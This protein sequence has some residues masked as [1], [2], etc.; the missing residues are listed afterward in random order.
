MSYNEED[1]L[2]VLT[3]KVLNFDNFQSINPQFVYKKRTNLTIINSYLKKNKNFL[4]I[5]DHYL[6]GTCQSLDGKLLEI[7]LT[8]PLN[9]QLWLDLLKHMT[10][11]NKYF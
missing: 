9:K 1:V 4:I 10:S 6:N 8:V 2:A 11:R 7:T 5:L 3:K